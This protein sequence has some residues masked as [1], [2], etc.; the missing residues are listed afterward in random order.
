MI[1]LSHAADA[2][3]KAATAANIA[4]IA[5]MKEPERTVAALVETV[6]GPVEVL[7]PE[8]FRPDEAPLPLGTVLLP[9]GEDVEPV[10]VAVDPIPL[11][12]PSD[13]ES[14]E[15][16]EA[17]A[18][19]AEELTD[20][21]DPFELELPPETDVEPEDAVEDWLLAE[22]DEDEETLLQDKS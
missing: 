9:V 6:E 18:P 11:P 16:E 20:P 15:P 21:D 1:D 13:G 12:A 3:Y 10:V 2:I 17:T 5:P 22:L 4:P 8:V 14:P 19:E 7:V